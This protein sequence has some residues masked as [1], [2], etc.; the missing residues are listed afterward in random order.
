MISSDD[1]GNRQAS[2]R[3]TTGR[4]RLPMGRSLTGALMLYRRLEP[5]PAEVPRGPDHAADRKTR[6]HVLAL[7]VRRTQRNC[8][9]EG[10]GFT[11][12]T[13]TSIVLPLAQKLAESV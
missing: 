3:G 7:P 13:V 1:S 4:S 9:N 8:V 12:T 5:D 6:W 11:S 2:P 10:V